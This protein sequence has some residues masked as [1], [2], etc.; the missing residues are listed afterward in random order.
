MNRAEAGKYRHIFI[1]NPNTSRM[2]VI[3][4][5]I[6][7]IKNVC[8]EDD[9]IYEIYRTNSQEA[10]PQHIKEL[11]GAGFPLRVYICGGDGTV[12]NI[13]SSTW[14]YKNV[15]Y[16][17][18]PMGTGN[19]FARNFADG[20]VYSNLRNIIYGDAMDIDL[21]RVNNSICV[22]MINIGF[23]EQVVSLVQKNRHIPFSRK[24][25]AYTFAALVEL[26]RM[27]MEQVHITFDDG[28]V[29]DKRFT[30]CAIANGAY[31][32]GGYY[33]ASNAEVDDGLID[34]IIVRPVHRKTLI[35]LIGKYRKGTLLNTRKGNKLVFQKKCR[36]MVLEKKVPFEVCI[37]GEIEM[38]KRLKCEI[39]PRA[40]K[41]IKP[42]NMAEQEII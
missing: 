21:L 18:I 39:I 25:I 4:V 5:L 19:D 23:D 3:E 32:G 31:C 22:N 33:A 28:E 7:R 10:G 41:F 42:V 1:V 15:E 27:P 30:L 16:A 20:E 36:Q 34:I 17:V 29:Y 14:E 24:Q 35:S 13:I 8:T 11:A 9:L 6:Q 37:D 38:T 2:P 40:V 12:K 26:I